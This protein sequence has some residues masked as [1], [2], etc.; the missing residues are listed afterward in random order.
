MTDAKKKKK[1]KKKKMLVI[2]AR[3]IKRKL[4]II[5]GHCWNQCKK[6]LVIIKAIVKENWSLLKPSW[7]KPEQKKIGHYWSSA[8]EYL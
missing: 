8:K 6:K 5:V 2:I 1:K 4:V 7:L 3:Q